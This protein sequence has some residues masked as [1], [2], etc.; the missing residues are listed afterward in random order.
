[1]GGYNT[2]FDRMSDED[3]N[4]LYGN[5]T[6]VHSAPTN[7][8]ASPT[9][10]GSFWEWAFGPNVDIPKGVKATTFDNPTPDQK[11]FT[12]SRAA[13]IDPRALPQGR[14]MLQQYG[15]AQ[16]DPMTGLPAR[17]AQQSLLDEY[18]AAARGEGPSYAQETL[19]QGQDQNLQN[20]LRIAAQGR[21]APGMARYAAGQQAGDLGLQGARQAAMLRAQE[22]EAARQGLGQVAGQMRGQD[23]EQANANAQLRQQTGLFNTGQYN[24]GVQSDIDRLL[25]LLQLNSGYQQQAN[26]QNGL[27]LQQYGALMSVN[28]KWTQEQNAAYQQMINQYLLAQQ[29]ASNQANA[30]LRNQ[31]IGTGLDVASN[32]AT[33]GMGGKPK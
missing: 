27:G 21:G 13:T 31:V 26:M 7:N 2:G 24:Q 23:F 6:I 14:S 19:R 15:G 25:Q 22:I 20:A 1:M 12:G 5:K 8:P 32:A 29:A 17:N 3:Y 18:G 4:R 10:S 33:L 11:Y 9:G 30:Q 28:S 16:L